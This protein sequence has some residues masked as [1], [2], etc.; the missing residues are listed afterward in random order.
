MTLTLDDLYERCYTD[1]CGSEGPILDRDRFGEIVHFA[2]CFFPQDRTDY[3]S[4][5][6]PILAWIFEDPDHDPETYDALWIPTHYVEYY[7]EDVRLDVEGR[8]YTLTEWTTESSASFELANGV[9]VRQGQ[10]FP[11]TVERL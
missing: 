1:L 5:H 4:C 9:W 7:D 8:A 2:A 11:G 3:E 10:T 6:G